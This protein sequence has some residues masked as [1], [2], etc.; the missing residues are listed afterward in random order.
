MSQ[1]QASINALAHE[2]GPFTGPL[3][4]VGCAR[5]G[6]TLLRHV[7]NR[8]PRVSLASET[9]FIEWAR[10]QRLD[11]RLAEARATGDEA[12][13]VAIAERL[14]SREFWPWVPRNF[15]R[16]ELV[17]L[18]RRTPLTPRGVFE[19]LLIEYA[20]RRGGLEPGRG[21]IGEKTPAHLREIPMLDAW[22][23]RARFIHTFRDPRGIYLSELRRLRQGRWGPKARYPGL[24][25]WL[26]DPFLAPVQLARTTLAWRRAVHV[27]RAAARSLGPRYRLVRFEDLV[28]DPERVVRE[29]CA[30]LEV[31]F[32]QA[33]LDRA[34]VVGSS[35]EERRH[36]GTGIRS[37]AATRWQEEIGALP[38]AWFS[39]AFAGDLPRFGYPA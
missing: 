33:M 7:L 25:N 1:L 37:G 9:H 19:L 23:P 14:H 18:L 17:A 8:S 5:T 24:P 15:A 20:E 11:A 29:V 12:E 13:L 27:H 38:R 4:M 21:V 22:F 30:F 39:A 6:S 16:D 2:E 10:R 34:D 26:V 35:F 28:A 36:A 32:E 3:F 31:P